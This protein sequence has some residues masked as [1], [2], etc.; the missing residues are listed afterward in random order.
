MA[1]RDVI[2][3]INPSLLFQ[4]ALL[5]VIVTVSAK[6]SLV[7]TKIL[8]HFLPQLIAIH[9]AHLLWPDSSGLLF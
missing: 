5:I 4:L 1:G 2:A 7:R 3:P 9:T 8:I 6:A